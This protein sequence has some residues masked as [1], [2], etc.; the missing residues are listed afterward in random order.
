LTQTRI[1]LL[2]IDDHLLFVQGVYSL[3]LD[4]EA[5]QWMGSASTVEEGIK[6]CRIEKPDI[7]L[8]DY[9][10]PD[11]TGLVATQKILAQNPTTRI[12]MLTMEDSLV[13]MEQCK[14]AGVLGFLPK[15]IGRDEL[16]K[17]LLAASKG[18]S[19][20]P[21]LREIKPLSRPVSTKLDLLSRREKEIAYLVAQGLSS[22]EIAKKLFL[23]LLTVNTHR[24]NMLGKLDIKNIAQLA[25]L[26]NGNSN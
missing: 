18:E 11:G 24:R 17:A 12:L 15:S 26:I 10:L 9:F 22:T 14:E 19:T 25:L 20:F 2:H 6:L 16:I 5:V 13:V 21:K 23:S 7:V 1:R 8:L 4:E 3:L